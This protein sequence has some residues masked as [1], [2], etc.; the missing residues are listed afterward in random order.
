MHQ[1]RTLALARAMDTTSF[2]V[3]CGQAEPPAD[4]EGHGRPTGVGDS[5]VADPYGTLVLELGSGPELA[6][7]DLDLSLVD[8]ARE[9]LPVLRNARRFES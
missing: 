2:V 9:R 4:G 7:V 8:E 6:V 1:W 5:V 3:A